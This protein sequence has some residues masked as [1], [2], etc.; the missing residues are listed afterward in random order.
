MCLKVSVCLTV[1]HAK[2]W[3]QHE[4]SLLSPL[5][6]LPSLASVSCSGSGPGTTYHRLR[7]DRVRALHGA[8][9]GN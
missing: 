4:N 5:D 6:Q 3:G 8:G 1:C 7:E 2:G 9:L